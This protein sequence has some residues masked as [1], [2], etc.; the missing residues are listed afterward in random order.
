MTSKVA[1]GLTGLVAVGLAAGCDVTGGEHLMRSPPRVDFL[2]AD[3]STGFGV[4]S[5][6]ISNGV[7]DIPDLVLKSVASKVRVATWPGDLEVPSTQTVTTVP[8]G[9]LANGAQVMSRDQID[10]Q[11][12]AALDGSGWYGVTVGLE[13]GL[14]VIDLDPLFAFQNG[15]RGVRLSPAHAPVVASVMSCSKD[16][17]TIAVYVRYSEPVLKTTGPPALDF[18]KY[19]V[20]CSVGADSPSETQF[21][22]V[23]GAGAGQPFLLNVPDG[24]TAQASGAPMAPATLDS[25]GM[26]AHSTSDGCT[27]YR[28][29]TVD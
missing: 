23:T 14:Y 4:A 3:L 29:W 6:Q 18:T 24:L 25:M 17:G 15:G 7:D 9:Q 1:A 26:Y 11:L 2:T 16:M 13:A 22:C 28:P 20:T 5:I 8:G 12:D 27:T 21:I 10:V 19:P